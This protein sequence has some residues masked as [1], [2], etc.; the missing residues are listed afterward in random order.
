MY[1]EERI[2]GLAKETQKYLHDKNK[3]WYEITAQCCSNKNSGNSPF[4][5]LEQ[6][7]IH[8]FY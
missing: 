6:G 8:Y 5:Y 3:R 1:M 2:T 7:T 4:S